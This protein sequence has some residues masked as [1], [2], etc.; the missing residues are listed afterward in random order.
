M[1]CYVEE[2]GISC[3]ILDAWQRSQDDSKRLIL[4]LLTSAAAAC[5]DLQVNRT[6][7]ENTIIISSSLLRN[8][9]FPSHLR[10][11]VSDK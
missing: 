3:I 1:P 5:L 6:L 9:Y 4:R 2:K 11:K 7:I 8:V 10:M